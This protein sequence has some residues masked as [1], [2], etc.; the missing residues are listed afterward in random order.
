MKGLINWIFLI[1]ALQS[2]CFLFASFDVYPGLEYPIGAPSTMLDLSS[3]FDF[4]RLGFLTLIGFGGGAIAASVTGILTRNGTFAVY[5][6]AIFGFGSFIPVIQYFVLAIPNTLGALVN[7][8]MI[9]SV[10]IDSAG[11]SAWTPILTTLG[12]WAA[13]WGALFVFGLIFQRDIQT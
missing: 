13:V 5:A 3:Y 7:A 9:N 4:E 8:T 6:M 1:V 12:L 10:I 11:T 2:A